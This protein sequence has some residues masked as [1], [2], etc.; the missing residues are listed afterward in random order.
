MA[1]ISKQIDK[2]HEGMEFG[3]LA[4]APVSIISGISAGDAELLQKAFGIKTVR[5]LAECKPFLVAQ[6]IAILAGAKQTWRMV[7]A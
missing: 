6:A 4:D 2:A 3:A 1:D 5:D 7:C